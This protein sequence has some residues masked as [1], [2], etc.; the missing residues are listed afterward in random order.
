[1]FKTLIGTSL[2]L[3]ILLIS[4]CATPT[5][6]AFDNADFQLNNSK[7]LLLLTANLENH[8]KPNYQPNLVVVN[9]EKAVVNNSEDR[10]NFT[11]DDNAKAKM[12]D[13]SKN[14]RYL[15]S[16]ELE[17]GDYVLRGLTSNSS[18][19]PIT[20]FF[21]TPI[22]EAL[23]LTKPGIYYL[24]HLDASVRE[25]KDNEFKAGSSIP[26]L[27]QFVVGASGGTFD[28]QI[29]DQWSVDQGY[30]LEKY[31]KLHGMKIKKSILPSFDQDRAQTWWENQ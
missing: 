9:V 30:F 6:M 12:K 28:V 20:G 25:R 23:N 27:D 2:L 10:I 17:N 8:Y 29:T 18:K 31:K 4:G 26:L 19:F 5:K 1:M 24:G 3:L 16:M 11:I 22:H 7:T 21:F 14:G 15:I 13:G